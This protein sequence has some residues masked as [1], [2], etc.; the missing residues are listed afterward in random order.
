MLVI[1]N[2]A[3]G[4]FRPWMTIP[5][6]AAA[7]RS[8]QHPQRVRAKTKTRTA[9]VAAEA[10]VS[11]PQ[12][13]EPAWPNAA[14]TVGT[15]TLIPITIKT[16]R[17]MVEP[18]ADNP[19]VFENELSDIDLAARPL[20]TQASAQTS[21][22]VSTDGRATTES[23]ASEQPRVFAMAETV[24]TFTQSA[25]FEPVLLVLAGALAALSAVRLFA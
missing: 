17:E 3:G 20:L 13:A 8:A 21:A 5:T 19:L 15:A 1:P 6:A 12:P 11:E 2:N 18:A 24:K 9:P 4:F 23:E 22:P 25:W 16:V 14:A 10:A 7:P